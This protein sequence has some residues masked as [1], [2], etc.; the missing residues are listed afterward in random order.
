MIINQTIS[1]LLITP[2][3]EGGYGP[4][5]VCLSI[6]AFLILLIISTEVLFIFYYRN[7][8]MWGNFIGKK[9]TSIGIG[10]IIS[11]FLWLIGSFLINTY[12]IIPYKIIGIVAVCIIIFFGINYL[13]YKVMDK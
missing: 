10:I 3:S 1:N 5:I 12:K 13:I 2:I 8:I 4:G 7:D 6:W 11:G 9:M